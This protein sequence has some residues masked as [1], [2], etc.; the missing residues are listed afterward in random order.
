MFH[1]IFRIELWERPNPLC[2]IDYKCALAP[3]EKNYV[4]NVYLDTCKNQ[5]TIISHHS[6]LIA[7]EDNILFKKCNI[8]HQ[9]VSTSCIKCYVTLLN[10]SN[11]NAQKLL[12]NGMVQ[13]IDYKV[14]N[15]QFVDSIINLVYVHF[16]HNASIINF[17]T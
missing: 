6:S 4:Q 8:I 9:D 15:G 16:V 17:C 11:E 1:Y 13:V 10:D 5:T 3:I 2:R 14:H 7:I 12:S